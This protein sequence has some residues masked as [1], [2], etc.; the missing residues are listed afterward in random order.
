VIWTGLSSSWTVSHAVSW[1]KY[2]WDRMA[3]ISW[4]KLKNSGSALLQST[5]RGLEPVR[6]RARSGVYLRWLM[7]KYHF[8]KRKS[9]SYVS[10]D[11]IRMSFL[12]EQV[13]STSKQTGMFFFHRSRTSDRTFSKEEHWKNTKVTHFQNYKNN[14]SLFCIYFLPTVAKSIPVTIHKRLK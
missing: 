8:S 2:S 13:K 9:S 6:V 5:N 14:L 12:Q 11:L 10:D 4:T 3:F 7:L 1:E